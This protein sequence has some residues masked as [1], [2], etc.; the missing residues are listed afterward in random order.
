MKRALIKKCDN[1]NQKY[2]VKLGIYNFKIYKN[3][4]E[5]ILWEYIKI[6]NEEIPTKRLYK[7]TGE[8]IKL[9]KE[10]KA[11]NYKRCNVLI[12][13]YLK[14]LGYDINIP[15]DYTDFDLNLDLDLDYH[16]TSQ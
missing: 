7:T 13:D 4:E 3:N 15:S 5:Y 2:K 14:K 9:P 8:R 11:L 6:F 12:L 10:I 16:D 1:I